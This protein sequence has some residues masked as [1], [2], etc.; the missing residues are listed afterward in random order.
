G[1]H[2]G[3]EV[4]GNAADLAAATLDFAGMDARPDFEPQGSD[5]FANLH[6]AVYGP[7]GTVERREKSIPRAVDFPAPECRKIAADEV[8]VCSAHFEPA[9]VAEPRGKLGRS[10]DVREQ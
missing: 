10:D 4:N 6:G 8:V 3:G 2:A 7:C 9:R 1:H 5:G